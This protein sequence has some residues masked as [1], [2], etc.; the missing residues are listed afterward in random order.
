MKRRR[1]RDRKTYSKSIRRKREAG[2]RRG[3]TGGRHW[4]KEN[5]EEERRNIEA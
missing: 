2:D 4:K 3:R 1:K 5:E